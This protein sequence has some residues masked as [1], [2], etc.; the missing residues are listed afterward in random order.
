MFKF[1]GGRGF[2]HENCFSR[3]SLKNFVKMSEDD[4]Y[5]TSTNSNKCQTFLKTSDFAFGYFYKVFKR[6]S[7]KNFVKIFFVTFIDICVVTVVR[8]RLS[9]IP[10]YSVIFSEK[11]F[12]INF[13]TQIH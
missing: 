5:G 9:Q 10:W 1:A 7:K 2:F 13:I 12:H 8:T 11:F 6:K 4:V 3:F